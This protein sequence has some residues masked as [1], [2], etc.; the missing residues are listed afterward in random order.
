MSTSHSK[1]FAVICLATLAA[2]G[3][4]APQSP[5]GKQGF[6]AFKMLRTRNIFDP[7][8]QPGAATPSQVSAAPSAGDYAALTGTMITAEKALAFFSGSRPDF[9]AVLSTGGKIAGTKIT[10]ITTDSVEV[11]RGGKRVVIAI[12]QTVP[13]DANSVP[14]PAPAPSASTATPSTPSAAP[15]SSPAPASADREA[16]RRRMME[17]RQQEIQ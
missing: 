6:E 12:G 2:T 17:K 8:R 15:G 14:G 11:E 7:E 13:L 1:L 16:V 4:T 10:N 5:S 9:N 3:W